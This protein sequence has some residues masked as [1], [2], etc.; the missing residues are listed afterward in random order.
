MTRFQLHCLFNV[1]YGSMTANGEW[2][3]VWKELSWHILKYYP[4]IFLGIGLL[5]QIRG[6]GLQVEIQAPHTF[7]IRTRSVN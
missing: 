7:R 6:S 3:K 5:N 1:K 4:G 2:E